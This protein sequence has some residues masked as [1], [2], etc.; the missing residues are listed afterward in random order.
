MPIF[1]CLCVCVFLEQTC[2]SRVWSLY[3]VPL[4]KGS[5]G[6]CF[7]YYSLTNH[8]LCCRSS[9]CGQQPPWEFYSYALSATEQS[10]GKTNICCGQGCFQCGL[11]PLN[12]SHGQFPKRRRG[13]NTSSFAKDKPFWR[14]PRLSALTVNTMVSGTNVTCDWLETSCI[15][16]QEGNHRGILWKGA[17]SCIQTQKTCTHGTSVPA[18]AHTHAD[19]RVASQTTSWAK[20]ENNM[21][22]N[23]SKLDLKSFVTAE[24]HSRCE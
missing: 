13:T 15:E 23:Y 16:G 9:L 10:R 19:G 11:E 6:N 7:C 20:Q 1:I 12:D 21:K 2:G 8:S 14:G 17:N 3:V 24:L 4:G 22:W 18:R 5:G